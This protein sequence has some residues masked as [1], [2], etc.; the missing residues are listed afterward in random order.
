[1][2]GLGEQSRKGHY[3]GDIAAQVDVWRDPIAVPP[4][5]VVKT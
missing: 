1:M 4:R 3:T 2:E 5:R